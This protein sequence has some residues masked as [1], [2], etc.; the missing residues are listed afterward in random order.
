MAVLGRAGRLFIIG[1]V[2][3]TVV[4]CGG[5]AMP[6]PTARATPI[7]GQ[8]TT[9]SAAATASPT[10]PPP[11]SAP[12]AVATPGTGDTTID[13]PAGFTV[14]IDL[15]PDFRWAWD[16]ASYQ[17]ILASLDPERRAAVE[18]VGPPMTKNWFDVY[19]VDTTSAPLPSGSLTMLYTKRSSSQWASIDDLEAS[20]RTMETPAGVEL[21]GVD[22]LDAPA[23]PMVRG[24]FRMPCDV[25]Q[26]T[27]ILSAQEGIEQVGM[28]QYL[29]LSAGEFGPN[30]DTFAF[31]IPADEIDSRVS[32]LDRIMTSLR[33]RPDPA[34]PTPSP[35]T[36]S[37][38]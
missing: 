28:V 32:D 19:A 33:L 8:V 17:A 3:A 24:V 34:A 23:G 1:S 14:D 10:A 12:A 37:A 2:V 25:S 38:P 7:G 36:S 13:T 21:V 9:P 26:A 22:R 11:A 6:Q 27:A 16:D 18:A 31:I 30:L 15:P 29:I 5:G 20:A 35:G 4:G